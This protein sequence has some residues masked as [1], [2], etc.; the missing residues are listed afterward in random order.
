MEL[1]ARRDKG[2]CY[3][4]NEPF[5]KGHRCQ[6]KELRLY[7]VANDLE[8]MVMEDIENEGTMVEV[9]PVV[10]LSL[11]SVEGL[12]TPS[13]FKIKGSV[14][15]KEVMVM[16]DC[17]VTHNFISTHLVEELNIPTA[18]TTSYGVIMGSKKAVQGK[19]MC[20]GVTVE[21]PVLTIVEDFLSLKLGNLNMVLGME[22]LRKQGAMTVD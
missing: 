13:T 5:N 3:R 8:D 6:N 4:C 22:W 11:N 21:L 9:S 20:K 15:G 19:G 10:E 1:L 7:L 17:G 2:L 16:I 14:E 12:T 18:E